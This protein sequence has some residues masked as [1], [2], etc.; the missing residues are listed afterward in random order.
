[1]GTRLNQQAIY[2]GISHYASSDE[3][4][5]RSLL[6]SK[7]LSPKAYFAIFRPSFDTLFALV[8]VRNHVKVKHNY[9]DMLLAFLS[10]MRIYNLLECSPTV[11]PH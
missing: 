4:R 7:F 9:H 5:R 2:L 1:M 11:K 3:M 6:S 8:S 10:H